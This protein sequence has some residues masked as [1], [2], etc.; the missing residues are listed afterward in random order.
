MCSLQRRDSMCKGPAG[1]ESVEHV[2]NHGG[3]EREGEG[4]HQ[5]G[6]HQEIWFYPKHT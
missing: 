4:T 6:A 2:Q 3:Q 5:A 1:E